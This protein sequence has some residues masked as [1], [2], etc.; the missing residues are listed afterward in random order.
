MHAHSNG[1]P[2]R[3]RAFQAKLSADDTR[4]PE[5]PATAPVAS[6]ST[7]LR[8]RL[9]RELARNEYDCIICFNTVA[10]RNA[11]WSC[12]RCCTSTAPPRY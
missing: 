5:E 8:S 3:R 2:Q 12:K 6:G 4:A 7:D 1:T 9:I 11:V 10:R